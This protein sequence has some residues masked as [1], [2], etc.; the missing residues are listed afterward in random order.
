M[1]NSERKVWYV[2]VYLASPHWKLLSK[3]AYSTLGRICKDCGSQKRLQLHHLSYENLWKEN[4]QRDLVVVCAD[5]HAK[6][7]GIAAGGRKKRGKYKP[8]KKKL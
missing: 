4:I 5:C 7:H 8:R 6:R 1:S 2:Q 3:I